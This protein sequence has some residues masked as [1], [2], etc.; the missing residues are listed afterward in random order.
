MTFFI[1]S[2][3][4]KAAAE[5]L[6]RGD[7]VAFPTETVYG[8]GGNAYS[9]TVVAKIFAY[10][11][12]P[13]LN[14]V[15]VCYPNLKAVPSDVE[16]TKIAELVAEKFLPGPVTLVL[17]RRQNCRIS[18]LCS[19]GLDTIGI[20]IPANTVALQLLSELNF[21]LALPSANTSGK[22][23]HTTAESVAEDIGNIAILDGGKCNIG[24]EST[25]IDCSGEK[26]II[27]RQ[28][29]V[30]IE[31]IAQ[32]CGISAENII[33]SESP[34]IFEVSKE[35]LLGAA[36]IVAEDDALLAF[37]TP[38]STK[39]KY[40]MNLSESGNIEEAAANFFAMLQKL[41]NSDAKRICVMPI[42]DVGLGK[43]INSRLKALA[44]SSSRPMCRKKR[45]QSRAE[46]RK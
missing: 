38:V 19:A 1:P 36:K 29:A 24:I 43:A 17:K 33:V 25:I 39:C 27:K 45:C 2:K 31:E 37:G 16:I 12:R 23:S 3:N 5:V 34:K 8:L 6:E 15:S 14:P 21:P 7:L 28:G 46:R 42:P 26:L 9:D 13:E 44:S 35:I 18:L 11:N 10:K 20:R 4:I 40:L 41:E 30:T 22:L 32:K